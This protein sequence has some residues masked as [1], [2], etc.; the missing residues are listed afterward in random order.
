TSTGGAIEW[1]F[2]ALVDRKTGS[3]YAGLEHQH[4]ILTSNGIFGVSARAG[5]IVYGASYLS[6]EGNRNASPAE[7]LKKVDAIPADDREWV[8]L[9]FPRE[10]RDAFN[11]ERSIPEKFAITDIRIKEDALAVDVTD[12]SKKQ[13]A[14]VTIHVAKGPWTIAA[15]TLNGKPIDIERAR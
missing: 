4:Y 5:G 1:K 14:E 8:N 3:V 10:I 7:L 2:Q 12:S 6:S 11:G 13:K 9:G 15:A